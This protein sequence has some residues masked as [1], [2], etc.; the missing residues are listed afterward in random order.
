MTRRR[1]GRGVLA[2]V[3]CLFPAAALTAPALSVAQ[4]RALALRSPN[5]FDTFFKYQRI[6]ESTLPSFM[7]EGEAVV[8][9][10]Q[11][12]SLDGVPAPA[13]V[14]GGQLSLGSVP[15]TWNEQ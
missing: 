9:P 8:G 2:A 4:L 13:H 6:H 12:I 10:V 3:V 15:W 1:G 5:V 7:F 14:A 11:E